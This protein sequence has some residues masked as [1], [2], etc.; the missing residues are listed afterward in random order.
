[1]T[2]IRKALLFG[3]LVW[4]LPFIVAVVIFPLRE[5]QRPLFESI[6]PVVLSGTVVMFGLRYLRGVGEFVA[7]EGLAVGVLWLVICVAID[8][9]LMLFGGPMRM[10]L[11]AYLADIAVTYL[12]V[13]VITAGLGI[14]FE[15]RGIR[16]A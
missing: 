3:F 10:T 2:S 14:A 9:P 13:P 11:G 5:T 6:M 12:M 16:P 7:R 8:V 1:M 15:R 4:F